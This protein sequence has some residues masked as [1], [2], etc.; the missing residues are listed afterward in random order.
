M[1]QGLL[2]AYL[3]VGPNE[4]KRNKTIARLKGRLDESFAT[5][6]LDEFS[7]TDTTPEA[8][9]SA[10][11]TMPLGDSFRVVIV[12]E[13][14]KLPKIAS[15]ALVRYLDNPNPATTL[16]LT[17]QTLAKT[18]RLYKA[19]AK[20]DK[21]AIVECA[22]MKSSELSL[23][24]QNLAKSHGFSIDDS[25]AQ[26][27]INRV[28]DSTVMLDAQLKTLAALG[29]GQTVTVSFVE[30]HVVRTAE[31]K[32]WTFLDSL[33]SRNLPRSLELYEMLPDKSPLG[34]LT[35]IT[36]RVRELICASSLS[37]RGETA[38]LAAELKKQ[39]WQVRSYT[40]WASAF[41]PGELEG[42]LATCA[43]CERELKSGGD[44]KTVMLKLIM[45]MCK[46]KA[47]SEESALTVQ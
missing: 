22:S 6:N 20:I 38:R 7:G 36:T 24:V 16:L 31:V 5:F 18:T 33:S 9:V 26:E 34:L 30:Q 39:Y 15:D 29:N 19:I 41:K 45:Q 1:A 47:N 17:A 11:Q 4:L 12:R 32:P 14:D 13:A 46:K 21:K 2:P 42:L 23:Y 37:S 8:L 40:A 28:G 27:L 43:Y 35:L 3:A 44:E 10:L 25:A